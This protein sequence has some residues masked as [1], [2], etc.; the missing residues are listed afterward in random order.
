MSGNAA[1]AAARRR[2]GQSLNPEIGVDNLSGQ[3]LKAYRSNEPTTMMNVV[4]EHDKK[5]FILERK[6]E[7]LEEI[8][9]EK[10]D[11]LTVEQENTISNNS[12]EIKLLKQNL[13][14]Q[15]KSIQE[16]NALVTS[17]KATVFTQESTIENL[18]DKINS[19]TSNVQKQPNVEKQ[20]NAQKPSS[21]KLD[22]SEK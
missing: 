6:V 18:N 2:R 22:I 13:Q 15:Q 19:N 1:L 12:S 5:V 8:D 16:L 4:L 20:P 17:L 21:V 10:S 11:G 14:K 7:K 9:S 3:G